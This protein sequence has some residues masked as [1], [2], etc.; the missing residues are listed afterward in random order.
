MSCQRRRRKS[1][2]NFF[3]KVL[4]KTE[5][6]LEFIKLSSSVIVHSSHSPHAVFAADATFP[7]LLAF[8]SYCTIYLLELKEVMLTWSS[9]KMKL[10]EGHP[11]H[12]NIFGHVSMDQYD[13]SVVQGLLITHRSPYNCQ[14]QGPS[15]LLD[16]RLAVR[17]FECLFCSR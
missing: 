17:V 16:A 13:Q 6:T 14:I 8:P 2:I 9:V 7:S 15:T 12:T 11:S 10:Q 4:S 1:L 5:A 3:E